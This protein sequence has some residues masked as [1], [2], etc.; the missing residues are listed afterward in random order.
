MASSKD[1]VAVKTIPQRRLEF[2]LL[3]V[4]AIVC[5]TMSIL[6]YQWMGELSRAERARLRSGLNEQVL[7]LVRA[8]D[9]GIS[10][11]CTALLPNAAEV[12]EEGFEKAHTSR[13]QEWAASHD[14]A[15]FS[16]IG[17]AAPQDGQLKLYGFDRQGRIGSTEWPAEWKTLRAQMTA[18]MNGTGP[19]P[20][21]PPRSMSIEV[22]VFGAGDGRHG[23]RAELEWMIFEVSEAYLRQKFLPR[24]VREYFSA[25]DE[26]L[27]DVSVSWP[28]PGEQV[29]YST[30]SDNAS[31]RRGADLA[32]PI[33]S[34]RVSGSGSRRG[35]RSPDDDLQGR[36]L[37][38]VRHREGS[39]DAAVS[40]A[41]TR[42]LATSVVL[43]GLLAGTGWA[44]VRYTARSRRLA[45]MQ[46]RFTAG[47][48]HDLRTPLT[49][50]RGAAYNIAEGVVTEP[51]ATRRY[52][53]LILRNAEELTSMIENVL[54]FSASLHAPTAIRHEAFEVR[55]LLEHAAAALAPEAQQAGCRVELTLAPDL[56]P[57]SGDPVA[58]ELAF[59]NLIGNAVRHGAQGKWVGV[60]ASRSVEGVE[61]RVSDRGPGIPESEHKRIFDP[62]YRSD[63]TRVTQVRGTGLGLSLV[64]DT[65]DR[66]GGTIEVRSSSAGGAEFIVRLPTITATV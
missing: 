18:R 13:Y 37:L 66:H 8:F 60:S 27:Y 43:I 21:V 11:S 17:I 59:R 7:R 2:G 53:S 54:A 22:P 23:E 32:M 31:V 64:K 6:Q 14:A 56:S 24:L 10:D 44:L 55:D 63:Q 51:D 46:L 33:F 57:I 1:L 16:R 25:G 35:R 19:A 62:F 47:V 12:R 29:V 48:S 34:T 30:R 52:A 45:S 20:S 3:A 42:N 39:L 15:L 50:I 26:A 4:L 41:R 5:T 9:E 61:V 49:A 40:G 65:V 38:A 36:W 28:D 58:L